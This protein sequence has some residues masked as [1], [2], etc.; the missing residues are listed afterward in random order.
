M[1]AIAKIQNKNI[2]ILAICKNHIH[3]LEANNI[4]TTG[5][6]PKISDTVRKISK[7]IAKPSRVNKRYLITLQ[8]N[9]NS[10]L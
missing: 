3:I 5:T 1:I 2:A 4:P 8:V 9:L 10:R 7:V 6:P